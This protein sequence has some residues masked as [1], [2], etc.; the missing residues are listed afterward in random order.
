MVNHP[1]ILPISRVK[2]NPNQ[3]A[4]ISLK[5][6]KIAWPIATPTNTVETRI[7]IPSSQRAVTLFGEVLSISRLIRNGSGLDES[8]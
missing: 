5:D 1:T 6:P 2:K 8:G 7:K 4:I 3:Y